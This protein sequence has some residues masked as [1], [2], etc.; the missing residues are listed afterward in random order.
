MLY[1]VNGERG[2]HS[3]V[4]LDAYEAFASIWAGAGRICARAA[5]LREYS[6]A[7]HENATRT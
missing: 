2:V 1:L 3:R 7:D 6:Q 5:Q 4:K